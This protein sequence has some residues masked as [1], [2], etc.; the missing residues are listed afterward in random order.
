MTG[1][2]PAQKFHNGQSVIWKLTGVSHSTRRHGTLS[3][4][5]HYLRRCQTSERLSMWQREIPE[6][7]ITRRGA[8]SVRREQKRRHGEDLRTTG[9]RHSG[10]NRRH[11]SNT[12]ASDRSY[13]RTRRR[14][15]RGT[16]RSTRRGGCRRPSECQPLVLRNLVRRQSQLVQQ[17]CSNR[18]PAPRPARQLP[19]GVR[20]DNELRSSG[21]G[22]AKHQPPMRDVGTTHHRTCRCSWRRH[23]R[24]DRIQRTRWRGTG[25]LFG[26]NRLRSM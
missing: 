11:R 1:P 16:G 2:Q 5:C 20:R 24:S 19:T 6:C 12:Q 17:G 8:E 3:S 14:H 26:G 15:Q 18:W 4:G 25:R 22:P 9:H 13:R 21:I 10:G 7:R 23:I